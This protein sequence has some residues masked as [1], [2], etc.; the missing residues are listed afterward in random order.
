[1]KNSQP[2]GGLDRTGDLDSQF[3][4]LRGAVGSAGTGVSQ[5]LSRA[6]FHH[7]ERTTVVGHPHLEDADDV[8]VAAEL[9]HEAGLGAESLTRPVG[10]SAAMQNLD[11]HL[12]IEAVVVV[13]E[14]VGETAAAQPVDQRESGNFR[15][16]FAWWHVR[17]SDPG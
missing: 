12:A 3:H 17:E 6:H 2:V 4:R 7:Q 13:P 14:N 16:G 10:A 8:G 5:V 1:M 9:G 11:G 15:G